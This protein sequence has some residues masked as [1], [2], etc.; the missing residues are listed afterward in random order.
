MNAQTK[1]PAETLTTQSVATPLEVTGVTVMKGMN[2][3]TLMEIRRSA[4][5]NFTISFI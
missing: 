4:G 3:I 5:V 1:I 2:G